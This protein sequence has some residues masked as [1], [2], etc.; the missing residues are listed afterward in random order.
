MRG[1]AGSIRY[2]GRSFFPHR[3]LRQSPLG[4]VVVVGSAAMATIP[5][6][7]DDT[8]VSL[9]VDPEIQVDELG[10]RQAALVDILWVIDN[11]PSMIQEQ[12]ALAANFERFIAG[13]TLCQGTGV[14]N[15]LC[16]FESKTCR[17]SG[18]ACNPPDYRIGVVSTDLQTET[19]QGRLRGVGVCVP[20]AGA[21]PANDLFRYCQGSNTDCIHDAADPNSSP[22]NSVCDFQQTTRF[23]SPAT[24]NARDAFSRLIQVGAQSGA[25]ETGIQAA[26]RALGQDVDRTT[27]MPIPAPTENTDFIRPEASLFVIFVSDEDDNS[28]GRLTYFYRVFETLKG[29]GNEGLVSLSAIVGPPDTDG[30]G[31]AGCI[32]EGATERERNDPGTR[33][34]AL[35]MYSRSIAVDFRVCDDARLTCPTTD[36][37]QMPIEG[38]PGICVPTAECTDDRS[39]GNLDCGG[40]GCIRCVNNQCQAQAEQFLPLLERNGVFASICSDYDR[41][42]DSLGF[43]AAGLSRKFEL[44]RF[45]DCGTDPV[46]CCPDAVDPADCSDTATLCVKVD[47]AVIANDRATGWIYESTT[48]AVFFDGDFIPATGSDVT[49][50]YRLS[51]IE[52]SLSCESVLR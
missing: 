26:A 18:E 46:P 15:D 4:L 7:C 27:G 30:D 12:Q 51:N 16:D 17:T 8:S 13:L 31:T 48:N 21:T 36:T 22:E 9:V 44:T 23:V 33:Y 49:L 45:P 35:S 40:Q 52:Q 28:P 37:C 25:F 1:E 11:S 50:S 41:V 2:M 20:A 38:L 5:A 29:A 6:G 19:D 3:R 34:I 10:Q 47:G 14:A 39:C 42:L 32:P 24:A 43:E